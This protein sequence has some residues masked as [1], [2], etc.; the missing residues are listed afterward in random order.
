M[1]KVFKKNDGGIIKFV[2][3]YRRKTYYFEINYES[4]IPILKKS[5]SRKDFLVLFSAEGNHKL[6]NSID[7][8]KQYVQTQSTL[9]VGS[10]LDSVPIAAIADRNLIQ[11]LLKDASMQIKL[12][13]YLADNSDTM[14][15]SG[16]CDFENQ[17]QLSKQSKTK[18]KTSVFTFRKAS[19]TVPF[20]WDEAYLEGIRIHGNID[21]AE[22]HADDEKTKFMKD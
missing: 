9:R 18:K 5:N 3:Q 20:D 19:K 4:M 15:D 21:D 7:D 17:P 1:K 22:C 10:I 11:S 2:D 6:C 16:Q 12:E 8:V 14:I 13:S